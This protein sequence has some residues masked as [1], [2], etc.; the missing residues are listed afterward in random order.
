MISYREALSIAKDYGFTHKKQYS[1]ASLIYKPL[2]NSNYIGILF[3]EV[4]KERS[5]VVHFGFG[6]N[7][8]ESFKSKLFNIP[9]N[10]IQELIYYIDVSPFMI[11]RKTFISFL[12][13]TD[14]DALADECIASLNNSKIPIFFDSMSN[15]AKELTMFDALVFAL[16]EKEDRSKE[17]ILKIFKSEK[18]TNSK[19]LSFM[20]Q[21]LK[22]HLESE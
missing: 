7:S 20:F 18:N 16:S 21:K 3:Y 4:G 5:L 14:F 1:P 9:E 8:V 2:E 22:N 12:S 19:R 13:T 6:N 10:L 11:N 15:D 17:D